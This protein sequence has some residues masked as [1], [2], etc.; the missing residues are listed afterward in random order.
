MIEII[1]VVF[2]VVAAVIAIYEFLDN[3][4]EKLRKKRLERNANKSLLSQTKKK[5]LFDQKKWSYRFT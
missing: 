4:K 5:F 3:N 2:T 1:S